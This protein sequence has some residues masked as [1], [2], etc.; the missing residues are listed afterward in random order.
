NMHVIGKQAASSPRD[1]LVALD[2]SRAI[3]PINPLWDALAR[4][5]DTLYSRLQR[6][7]TYVPAADAND[8]VDW[9]KAVSGDLAPYM[10][11]FFDEMLVNMVDGLRVA[12]REWG[13][14]SDCV[15]VGDRDGALSAID[16]AAKAIN[17]LS[18]TL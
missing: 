16:N 6:Y 14:Y 4:E 10:D 13:Y 15:I 7:Q 9:M 5:L 11:Q 2:N 8:L 18:P 12:A 1:A 3:D 17:N